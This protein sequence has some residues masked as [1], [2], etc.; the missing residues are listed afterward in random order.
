[1][2]SQTAAK[3]AHRLL[4]GGLREFDRRGGKIDSVA[5]FL[6]HSKQV[7]EPNLVE[8][9][10][11]SREVIRAEIDEF[12]GRTIK[13]LRRWFRA[14]DGRMRPTP[15]GLACAIRHLPAL[16]DLISEALLR[17]RENGL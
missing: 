9:A 17:A 12:N 1:M 13:N 15:K 16:A 4:G 5:N 8:F 6:R 3:A 7:S 11:N 10:L 2:T 14:N